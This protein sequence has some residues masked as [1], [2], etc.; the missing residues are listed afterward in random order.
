M[1]KRRRRSL[2]RSVRVSI[3]HY[4]SRVL[5]RAARPHLSAIED[6]RRYHP[7]NVHRPTMRVD[8]RRTE[9]LVLDGSRDPLRYHKLAFRDA[10]NVV[11]CVRRKE[12]REVLFATGGASKRNKRKR[13][14]T[15][16]SKIR[17]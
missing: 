17:C 14:M 16:R 15:W 11:T 4:P 12:R 6:R 8:G 1:A 9:R 5:R 3:H 10:R 13:R 7:L 2:S